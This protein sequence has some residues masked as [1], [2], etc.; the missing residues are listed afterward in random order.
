MLDEKVNEL[1][2][3]MTP[4]RIKG[5]LA[6]YKKVTDAYSLQMPD[7]Y[8]MPT[9]ADY[10][11]AYEL[12]PSEIQTNYDLY[13]QS[14]ESPMPF[15]LGTPTVSGNQLQFNWSE[16]YDFNAQDI[17]YDFVLSKDWEFNEIVHQQ[18]L[19]NQS[20]LSI[21]MLEPGTYFWSVTAKNKDGKTMYPFDVYIDADGNHHSGVKV[22]YISK[23]GE[24]SEE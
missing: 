8:Y 22:L 12:L 5:M 24:V 19:T 10:E 21:D 13:R 16:S 7:E 4:D 11:K 9:K 6:D 15:F 23:S 17:T 18:S 2:K 3:F 1:M 20:S 14:L